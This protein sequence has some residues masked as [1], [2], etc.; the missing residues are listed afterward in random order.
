V[1]NDSDESGNDVEHLSV[2]VAEDAGVAIIRAY[3][4]PLLLSLPSIPT[5]SSSYTKCPLWVRALL[6]SEAKNVEFRW[7]ILF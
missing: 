5:P 2:N 1:S 6:T 3:Q 4:F 7:F